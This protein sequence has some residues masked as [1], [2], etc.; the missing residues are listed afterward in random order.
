MKEK[1]KL[2]PAILLIPGI[3]F[4]AMVVIGFGNP[5]PF[6]NALNDFYIAMM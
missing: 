1:I 5:V 3:I 6:I 2:R 4:A